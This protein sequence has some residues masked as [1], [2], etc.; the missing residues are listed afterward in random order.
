MKMNSDSIYRVSVSEKMP[1]NQF[2]TALKK[3]APIVLPIVIILMFFNCESNERFYRPNLPEKLCSIGI[4]DVDDTTNYLAP[5]PEFLATRNITRYIS[6]EKSFQLEYPEE[7]KDSLREF[8]FNISTELE[9][10][11]D[12]QS[13][14]T[15]KNLLK[16]KIPNSIKF[17]SGEKYFLRSREKGSNEI[18][19]EVTVP[20]P[21]PS[22]SLL[23]VNNEI[24]TLSE[25]ENCLGTTIVK[26]AI[27][28][29]SFEN[30]D[31]KSYYALLLEGIGYNFSSA[32]LLGLDP[33]LLEFTVKEN[34]TSGFF[35]IMHGLKMYQSSCKDNHASFI[36]CP[37]NAFFINGSKISDNKCKIKISTQFSD[38]RAFYETIKSFRIKLLSIPE[39]LYFFEK[40][41]YTYSKVNKDPFSEPV[42][43][44]GN[45]KGGNGV[46]AI[47]RSTQLSIKLSPWY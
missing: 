5:F 19:A 11:F 22:L 17:I 24:T 23:S 25:P 18:S 1:T 4:I 20:D 30:N 3:L 37:V 27:I 7:V 38:G 45:I 32:F 15:I 47:C 6:F 34:N 21:P 13:N 44:N 40:S 43:L 14:Q 39:E 29:L 41:L 28:E 10:I 2:K 9:E 36:Q 35:A 42:Y 46:F 31:Q 16:L 33:Y 12:Y 26:S 8:S